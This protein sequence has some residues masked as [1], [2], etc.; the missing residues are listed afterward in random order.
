MANFH[1]PPQGFGPGSQGTGEE[2]DFMPLPSGMRTYAAHLPE[3]EPGA[4]PRQAL[5]LIEAIAAACDLTAADGEPRSVDV[6][7]LGTE[8]RALL[9]ETL[10]QGEVAMKLRGVPAVAEQESVFAGVWGLV[11]DGV[12]RVEIAPCP[13]LAAARAAACGHPPVRGSPRGTGCHRRYA[14]PGFGVPPAYAAGHRPGRPVPARTA[15]ASG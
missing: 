12:D 11:G 10:G 1:L 2:L 15:Q 13:A 7:F 14:P 8:A 5:D 6:G 3:V 9:S 4:V